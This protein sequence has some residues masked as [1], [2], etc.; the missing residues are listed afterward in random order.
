[1]YQHVHGVMM[2]SR[3][4][5]WQSGGVNDVWRCMPKAYFSIQSVQSYD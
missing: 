1:M 3:M 4:K 2:E 5:V